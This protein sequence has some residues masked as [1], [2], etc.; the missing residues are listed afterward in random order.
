MAGS[1]IS[2]AASRVSRMPVVA[3]PRSV[4]RSMSAMDVS[5]TGRP[6][7]RAISAR[8]ARSSFT[9]P[10]PIV[11]KPISPTRT[12]RSGTWS[13]GLCPP[14]RLPEGGAEGL[15]DAADRLPRPVLVLDERE[16]HELIAALAEAD[17]RRHRHLGLVQQEL[18]ELERAHRLVL[19]GDLGPH[20]HRRLRLAHVPAGA[21]HALAQ[22][23]A[24]LAIGLADL[25]H[26][27]LRTVERVR[28]RDLERLEGAVVE[29][30]LD[31][32]ERRDDLGMPDG[33]PDA[34]PRHV[35]AL[36]QGEELDADVARPGD[37]EERRRLVAVE[38]EV[39]VRQVVHHQT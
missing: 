32:G 39:G 21:L 5:K 14:S 18:R 9:T 28:G 15:L 34:P 17:P 33:E 24:P 26:V 10:A 16:A 6:A 25:V 4:S 12:D 2:E 30:A 38:A 29:V 35:V 20:E 37:L 19:A 8:C 31:A 7:R 11:P 3:T 27:V 13:A 23:V 36:R 22:H 1:A